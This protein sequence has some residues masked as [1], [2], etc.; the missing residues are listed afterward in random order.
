MNLSV[1]DILGEIFDC[2]PVY[3]TCKYKKSNRPSYIRASKPDYAIPL[4]IKFLEKTEEVM[5][6]NLAVEYLEL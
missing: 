4:Y 2:Q 1:Q 5:G 6:I 3:F